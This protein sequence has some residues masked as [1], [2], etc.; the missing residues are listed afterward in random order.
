M[1]FIIRSPLS[2]GLAAFSAL[3]ADWLSGLLLANRTFP[4]RPFAFA[5]SAWSTGPTRPACRRGARSPHVSPWPNSTQPACSEASGVSP[6]RSFRT[7]LSGSGPPRFA[8]TRVLLFQPLQPLCF[9]DLQSSVLRF[10]RVIGRFAGSALSAD[11]RRPH[12]GPHLLRNS[13]DLFLQ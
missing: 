11:L 1:D 13:H 4:R 2:K 12:P 10:P 8:S 5:L 3:A 7:T 9:V 6:N